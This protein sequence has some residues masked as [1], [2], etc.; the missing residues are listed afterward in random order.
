MIVKDEDE[1]DQ[2]KNVDFENKENKEDY[3][4]IV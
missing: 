3:E 1:D 2:V 4:E